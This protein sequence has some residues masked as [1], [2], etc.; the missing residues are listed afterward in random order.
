[1]N[2]VDA[3]ILLYAVRDESYKGIK[4]LELLEKQKLVT[5]LLSLDEVA[6]KLLRNSR[7]RAIAAVS[8][9]SNSP[10]LVLVPFLASD[11]DAFKEFLQNGFDPRDAIHALTAK[12]MKCPVFYSEDADFDKAEDFVRKTP[13]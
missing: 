3:N 4:A 12:K 7:E 9:F 13:W 2:Y 8:G 10:N 1:M 11:L 5:S 6:Y